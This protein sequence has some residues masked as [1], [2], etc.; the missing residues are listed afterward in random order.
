M[1]ITHISFFL[2]EFL[3][4]PSTGRLIIDKGKD[5]REIYIEDS[6][7]NYATS[8]VAGERFGAFLEKSGVYLAEDLEEIIKNKDYSKKIGEHLIDLG[9]ID[10]RLLKEILQ[11]QTKEIFIKTFSL[12][13]VDYKWQEG[14]KN[15]DPSFAANLKLIS[16]FFEG[17][18]RMDNFREIEFIVKGYFRITGDYLFA[19]NYLSEKEY[20]VYQAIKAGE[21]ITPEGFNLSKEKLDRILFTLYALGLIT[22]QKEEDETADLYYFYKKLDSLNYYELLGLEKNAS[23]KAIKDAY[24]ALSKR[25]HP[26]RF[27][28]K[29]EKEKEMASKVFS[30]L[31]KAYNTLIDPKARAQYEKE[32]SRKIQ[33]VERPKESA[34]ERFRLGK[35]YFQQK[36]FQEAAYLFESA[37]ELEESYQHLLWLG[38]ALARIPNRARD[39]EI[40]LLKA[41]EMAPWDPEPFIELALLYHN[42]GLKRKSKSMLEKAL[43]I[44]PEDPRVIKLKEKI[45]PSSKKKKSFL[46]FFKK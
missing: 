40:K 1:K 18:R 31:T 3:K 6:Y 4:K 35:R 38:K 17:L 5:R 13:E 21:K 10:E 27:G 19:I 34:E 12:F 23:E 24:F 30:A 22:I 9:Y 44:D 45:L 8:N 39:A 33:Q 36:K 7:V 11:Y 41:S 14:I 2:R 29:G 32:L 43:A 25:F 26:D 42:A 46:D 28:S 37:L 15:P 16:L 20:L